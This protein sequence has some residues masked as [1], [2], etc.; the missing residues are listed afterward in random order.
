MSRNVVQG[1]GFYES[2]PYTL[3]LAQRVLMREGELV[4]LAPKSFDLLLALVEAGGK[5]LSKEEL[6]KRVWPDT[7]VEEGSLTQAIFTLRKTLAEGGGSQQYIQTLSKRGY[8]F[9]APLT[10]EVAP[11]PQVLLSDGDEEQQEPYDGVQPPRFFRLGRLGLVSLVAAALIPITI[12]M[13]MAIARKPRA[14]PI[15]SLAVLPLEDLSHDP[16][17]EFFAEGMTDELINTL[18][19]I[20]ALRVV[21]RT[22]V[23]Q[24]AGS[25]KSLPEIA[26]ELDVDAIV[27]GTVLRASNQVRITAQLV[28]AS[29]EQH[30]WAETYQ[31][32]VDEVLILQDKVAQAV[33]HSIQV[34]LTPQERNLL[35]TRRSVN[36]EAYEAY[37]KGVYFMNHQTPPEENVEKAKEAF[38]QATIKDPSYA[39]GWSGLGA[40]YVW[41]GMY[42]AEPRAEAY[43]FA[44]KAAGKALELDSDL[45]EA[46]VVLGQIKTEYEW[47]WRQAERMFRQAIKTNP[48]AA[49]SHLS[50]ALLL[51][52][53]GRTREAVAE[54][55]RAHEAEP[56]HAGMYFLIG[57]YSYIDH[58]YEKAE[59]ICLEV[60]QRVPR[61]FAA[62]DCLAGVYLQTGRVQQAV[63][64][65]RISAQVADRG[66]LSL[67]YLGNTLGVS[68]ADGEAEKVLHEMINLSAH[69]YVPPEYI[70]LIYL[71]LGNKDLAFQWLDAAVG[72][73]SMQAWLYPDPRLDS[74]RSDPRFKQLSMRMGLL[75]AA[76][77]RDYLRIAG[78]QGGTT[79]GL[80]PNPH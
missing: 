8:R 38:Q 60:A 47:D 18:A 5:V 75:A 21:S 35:E 46:L 43:P 2:G 70:A 4:P 6:M 39:L 72:Q 40:A 22:S 59:R 49:E 55:Q 63:A 78:P 52:E 51:A 76:E 54:A 34:K 9:V 48:N 37:L 31:G 28:R 15:R 41:L 62:H 67:A 23:I 14:R 66:V 53:V 19:K 71:G 27:E 61:F 68:G 1:K 77:G 12:A 69:R 13:N 73:R 29:P 79:S 24:Y 65:A 50:Y 44:S 80:L 26:R 36:A 58:Q 56:R 30:L 64:E 10:T 57:W 45:P 74:I 25:K 42:G 16:A 7:F 33:A 11:E 17:Q 32:S 3:D 20:S